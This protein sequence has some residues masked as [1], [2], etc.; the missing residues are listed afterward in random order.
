MKLKSSV[1][2]CLTL[3]SVGLVGC[4]VEVEIDENEQEEQV[5]DSDLDGVIDQEDAFPFDDSEWA[6]Q[7]DDGV[8]DN[9]DNC[10]NIPNANQFDDN[11]DGLGDACDI[12]AAN[13]SAIPFTADEANFEGVVAWNVG[14]PAAE[15]D[16]TGHQIPVPY[17]IEDINEFA[18]YYMASRDYAGIN[19][20]SPG[21]IAAT[22]GGMTGF[23]NF[24]HALHLAG[25]SESD[26]NLQF[27][28]MSLGADIEGQDW[29]LVGSLE[30]RFYT[31]GTFTITLDGEVIVSAPMPK[32][33]LSIEY[34]EAQNPLDDQIFGITEAVAF[35]LIEIEDQLDEELTV[36]AKA[37][38]KDIAQ[39]SSGLRLVF[40]S[41][42]P[43][44]QSE[45]VDPANNRGGAYFEPQLG[46][47][48]IV[49][50]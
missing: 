50:D 36:I 17:Y 25:Y 47:L 24:A 33:T 18:Y 45:Y 26:I 35:H 2:I 30:T 10:L 49:H 9:S 12:F 6:D 22:D 20:N 48:E 21:V 32:L 19:P 46:K 16:N 29:T 5:Q 11:L 4:N 42:Q 14:A 27:G 7:D 38:L 1:L 34:N 43:A 13:E 15:N 40:D 8:G 23:P 37:F 31:G 44:G 28:L 41:I 39:S 3:G